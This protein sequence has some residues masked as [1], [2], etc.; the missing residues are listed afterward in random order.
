MVCSCNTTPTSPLARELEPV[1]K[2]VRVFETADDRILSSSDFCQPT[3]LFLQPLD[4]FCISLLVV[5]VIWISE[6][7]KSLFESSMHLEQ[8]LLE[9]GYPPDRIVFRSRQGGTSCAST[10]MSSSKC[11]VTGIHCPVTRDIGR[12]CRGLTPWKRI[13]PSNWV[14]VVGQGY[15]AKIGMF[16]SGNSLE[17]G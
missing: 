5:G 16:L 7:W 9:Y 1:P 14:Q 3:Y 10:S 2:Q 12:E 17:F 13:S 11:S 4:Y 6:S 8:F 15:L